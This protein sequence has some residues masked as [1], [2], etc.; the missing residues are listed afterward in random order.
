M[1]E[2]LVM[3]AG[4]AFLLGFGLF[5]RPLV[6][7]RAHVP[8]GMD[9]IKPNSKDMLRGLAIIIA[10]IVAIVAADMYAP[11]FGLPL[12]LACYL[13]ASFVGVLFAKSDNSVTTRRNNLLVFEVEEA[14]DLGLVRARNRANQQEYRRLDRLSNR[15]KFLAMTPIWLGAITLCLIVIPSLIA[16]PIWL[17]FVLTV[18]I[19]IYVGIDLA[20]DM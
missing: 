14:N 12:G 10:S 1:Y 6:Q 19:L 13:I 3:L 17:S 9:P 7:K 20:S 15:Y 18:G 4:T 5:V 16:L 2:I 11:R 8:V